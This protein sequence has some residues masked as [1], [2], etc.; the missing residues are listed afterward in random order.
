VSSEQLNS[1]AL[2][3][4]VGTCVLKRFSEP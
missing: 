1:F 2:R 3:I 4:A